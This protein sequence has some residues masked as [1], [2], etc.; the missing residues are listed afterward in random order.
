MEPK[1]RDLDDSPLSLNRRELL[2]RC[3]MGFGLIGLAGIMADDKL[4]GSNVKGQR[5]LADCPATGPA[6]VQISAFRCESQ[7][8][9]PLVHER[10]SFAHRYVRPQ[11]DANEVPRQGA[12]WPQSSHRTQDRCGPGLTFR[13]HLP[14]ATPGATSA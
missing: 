13:L 10:R 5:R 6:G 11:A 1:A 7:A 3:G 9:R 12:S 2:G 4:G 8:G 14:T